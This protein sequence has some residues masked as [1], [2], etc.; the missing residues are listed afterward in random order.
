MNDKLSPPPNAAALIEKA[1]QR[2]AEVR[3]SKTD[4]AY[5]WE[6]NKFKGF[7]D[8]QRAKGFLEKA[9][10]YLT[11]ESIDLYCST[12]VPTLTC[13]PTVAKRI[14][15]ALQFFA[16]NIEHV[17]KSFI[18]SSDVMDGGFA[19]Q[20]CT[21][22]RE[23]MDRKI[24]PHA[25]LPVNQLTNEEHHRALKTIFQSNHECW[26]SLASSWILGT[27]SFIRC[28]TFLSLKLSLRKK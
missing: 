12:V 23:S 6:W 9:D 2:N 17:D 26:V 14:R 22:A 3:G 4:P 7:V 24:D 21:H 16:D 11:Q 18:V 19:T 8:A 5:H 28:D 20:A 13:T 15:P 1:N 25:N 27:H 10:V